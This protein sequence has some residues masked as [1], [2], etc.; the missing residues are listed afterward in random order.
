MIVLEQKFKSHIWLVICNFSLGT[1]DYTHLL[2][3]PKQSLTLFRP[4]V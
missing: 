4:L 1:F 2:F 3:L